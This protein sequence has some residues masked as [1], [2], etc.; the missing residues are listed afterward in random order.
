VKSGTHGSSTGRR[1][2]PLSIGAPRLSHRVAGLSAAAAPHR[3]LCLLS[4]SLVTQLYVCL[5]ET[6]T[7]AAARADE[8]A[9]RAMSGR[10]GDV[11]VGFSH[12]PRRRDTKE[13][14]PAVSTHSLQLHNTDY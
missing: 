8:G 3:F 13:S 7:L 6:G 5:L 11:S 10:R 9:I 2:L 12:L 4:Q 1:A 14:S